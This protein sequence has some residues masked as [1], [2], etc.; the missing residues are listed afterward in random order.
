MKTINIV[1]DYKNIIYSFLNHDIS[2]KEFQHIYLECFK[3]EKRPLEDK[4]YEIL[5]ELF[6]DTDMYTSDSYLLSQDPKFYINEDTLRKKASETLQKLNAL[7][8]IE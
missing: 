4:L 8:K 2:L 5:E 6:G 7:Y 1:L 3:K